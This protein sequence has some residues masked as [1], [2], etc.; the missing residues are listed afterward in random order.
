M[1]AS[2]EPAKCDRRELKDWAASEDPNGRARAVEKI[3]KLV[4]KAAITEKGLRCEEHARAANYLWN[5]KAQ[6]GAFHRNQD[7]LWEWQWQSFKL[8]AALIRC[9]RKLT[10]PNI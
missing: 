3:R 5:Q 1:C 9:L 10:F 4:K 6:S 8:H 7:Q 2:L